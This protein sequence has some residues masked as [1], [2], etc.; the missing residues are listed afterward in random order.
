MLRHTHEADMHPRDMHT[1]DVHHSDIPSAA[2]STTASTSS[3]AMSRYVCASSAVSCPHCVSIAM[4]SGPR[5]PTALSSLPPVA[6]AIP[7]PENDT[8]LSQRRWRSANLRS[9][10]NPSIHAYMHMLE[11][12]RACTHAHACTRACQ[13]PWLSTYGYHHKASSTSFAQKHRMGPGGHRHGKGA[14]QRAAA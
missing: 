8:W 13:R 3:F 12:M 9:H 7:S 11:C 4:L 10:M 14:D 2:A 5:S 6:H 1:A